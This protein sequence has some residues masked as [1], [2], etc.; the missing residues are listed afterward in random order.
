MSWSTQAANATASVDATPLPVY[1]ADLE[2]EGK[3]V[4]RRPHHTQKALDQR[5][6]LQLWIERKELEKQKS[7]LG[8]KHMLTSSRRGKE[9]SRFVTTVSR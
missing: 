7:S 6:K 1:D 8:R 5:A 2:Q 4:S 3:V 9:N